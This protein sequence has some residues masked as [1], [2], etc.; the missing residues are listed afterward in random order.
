MIYSSKINLSHCSILPIT[1]L[2][3]AGAVDGLE[4]HEHVGEKAPF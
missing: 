1:V 2:L 3:V 4:V